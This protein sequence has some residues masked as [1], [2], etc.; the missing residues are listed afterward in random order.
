VSLSSFFGL[1]F[2]FVHARNEWKKNAR[3]EI[4]RFSFLRFGDVTGI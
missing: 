4:F 3:G 1:W 2:S